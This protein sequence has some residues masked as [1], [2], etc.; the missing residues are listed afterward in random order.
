MVVATSE[1]TVTYI[2]WLLAT[3]CR[4]PLVADVQVHLSSWIRDNCHPAHRVLSRLIY[5]RVR[6]LRSVS[7][8]V[9]DDLQAVFHVRRERIAVIPVPFDLEEIRRESGRPL[10]ARDEPVFARPVIVCAGRLTSQKRFDLAIRSF[11]LLVRGRGLDANLLIL[12]EGEDRVALERQVLDLGLAGRVFLPGQVE[13]IGAYMRRAAVFLLSSDYE[14]FGRVLVEAL[15]VDCPCVS[16]DC[17]SGP[18]EILDG[19]RAG[20]LVPCGD[21][22]GLARALAKVLTEPAL[23]AEMRAAG[24]SRVEGFATGTVAQAY[25][26]WLASVGTASTDEAGRVPA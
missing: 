25:S 7:D 23:A 12:G 14:G 1:L 6:A 5:P 16:T 21:V 13:N 3:L 11:D 15:A 18:A 17:P 8:G 19:G 20:L 9:S 24:S 22:E 4:R 10:G 2:A 26:R